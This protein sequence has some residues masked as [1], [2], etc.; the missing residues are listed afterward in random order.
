MLSFLEKSASRRILGYILIYILVAIPPL[1]N[2]ITELFLPQPNFVLFVLHSAFDP[3]IGFCNAI[4]Y[5]WNKQLRQSLINI[6]CGSEHRT[7]QIE[8]N[9]LYGTG[10]IGT[11]NNT[12][13][14]GINSGQDGEP[15][16]PDY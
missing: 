10:N 8:S 6:C 16:Q 2:R 1:T 15:E 7:L 12:I 14:S 4:V 5:G 9:S 11:L 3:L 13:N